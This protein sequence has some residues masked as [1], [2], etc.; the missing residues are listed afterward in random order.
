MFW[1]INRHADFS[2]AWQ[3]VEGKQ[4]FC[5]AIAI[6]GC[7]LLTLDLKL[8]GL[9]RERLVV[10]FYRLRGGLQAAGPAAETVI[11]LCADTGFN[12]E[13]GRLPQC[14][15]HFSTPCRPQKYA[16]MHAWFFVCC[17]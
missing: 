15:L 7:I 16:E 9:A 6:L 14:E 10:A 13:K 3:A 1:S 4:L 11:A 5:E 17:C 8:P 12:A 2:F